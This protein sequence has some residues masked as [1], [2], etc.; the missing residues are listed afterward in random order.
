MS[1]SSENYVGLEQAIKDKY[2]CEGGPEGVVV[3]E[4]RDDF[5]ECAMG[6]KPGRYSYP[7]SS[8]SDI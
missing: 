6:L 3:A 4:V 7:N 1:V 8:P 5:K 2:C